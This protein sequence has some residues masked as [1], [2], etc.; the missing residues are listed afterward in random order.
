MSEM[1]NLLAIYGG[2]PVSKAQF[3]PWPFFAE[4]EVAVVGKVLQSGK[5]NYW[6]GHFCRD[7]EEAFARFVGVKHAI[8]L[9]NGTVALELA[10][11]AMG[12]GAGDEVIVPSRTFIASASC[13][14]AVGAKPV[15][16][17]VDPISQN[18]TAE[19]IRPAIS[20]RTKAIVAVHLAGWPCDMD[21]IMA[22]A[23]EHD[24]KVI[25]DCAQAHGAEYKGRPVGSMGDCGAFSFCQDKIMTTGG[26]GG[27]LVTN[28]EALWRNAW[29]YK[30]HGKSWDA[31]Y[32]REHPQGFRWLHDSFGSNGRMTEMQAAI[33]LLQLEKLPLW[34][35]SRQKNAAFLISKLENVPGVRVPRFPSDVA[36]AC[37]KFYV[38]L[39]PEL[40]ADGW[41]QGAILDA[42]NAEG[43]PCLAGSCSE[44]Y[45]EQAFAAH[46]WQPESR[47]PVAKALGE[48]SLMFMIHP[49][50]TFQ[51]VQNTA[52]AIAKVMAVA[53]TQARTSEIMA[54]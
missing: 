51:D 44:I 23:Q 29:E 27:M 24:L 17:D 54:G 13:A 46:G 34:R 30:D 1:R 6:T 9:S 36:H 50:L 40:L 37:Y 49:T 8:S 32:R 18:L 42:I 39:R 19:T 4:D 33:G 48:T 28:N 11:R 31:I 2:E 15:V 7:F 22:L 25:E 20:P 43:V 14:V 45:R 52:D 3:A 12:V 10:L 47:L 53:T 41:D 35:S 26:E 21:S 38:F 16:V 5:V